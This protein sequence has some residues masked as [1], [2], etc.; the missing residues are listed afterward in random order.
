MEP[1]AT[2]TATEFKTHCLR[3]LDQLANHKLTRAH[4]TKRGKVSVIAY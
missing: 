2:F 3:I 1:V 4:V